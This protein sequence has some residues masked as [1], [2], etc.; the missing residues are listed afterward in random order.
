MTNYSKSKIYEIICKV[1]DERYIGSTT[2]PLSKRLAKHRMSSNK[3]S[4]RQIIER[5]DYYINLLEEFPCENKE[6]LLKKEREWYDKIICINKN[7]P[8]T[9]KEERIEKSAANR[10]EYR[11]QNKEKLVKIRKEYYQQNKDEIAKS[12]KEYYVQNKEK[13]A[14]SM[15]EYYEQNKDK[16]NQK[17]REVYAQQKLE[18]ATV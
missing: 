9:S 12:M 17:A 14:K 4:S 16:I 11:E 1:T 5:G 3:C 18:E 8:F 6:Q 7:R 2:Q 15:K 10:K 13:C